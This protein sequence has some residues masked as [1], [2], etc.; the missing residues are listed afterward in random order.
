MLDKHKLSLQLSQHKASEGGGATAKRKGSSSG[1][2]GGS[3]GAAAATK[4]VVRNVAFEATKRELL[5]LFG[6][7]GHVKSCR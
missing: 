1:A 6:P 7:F 3:S 2:E 5:G 4:L